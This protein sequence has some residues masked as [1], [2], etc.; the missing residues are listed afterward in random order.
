[1]DFKKKMKY[2]LYCAVAFITLGIIM[3]VGAFATRTDNEFVSSFGL[4]MLVMGVVRMRNYLIITKD[5]D[6]IKKQEV[7]ETD[8]RNLLIIYRARSAA[9]ITYTL[10]AGTSVI[11]LSL[12]GIH[13][14]ARWISYS[15]LSIMIIY[16]IFY[17]AIRKKY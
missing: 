16:L 14:A 5:E 6:T 10:L 4:A 7:V 8:E 12:L 3:I 17:Y 2:R 11:V 13:E 9:F 15:V 1:M